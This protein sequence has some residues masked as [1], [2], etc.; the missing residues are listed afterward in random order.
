MA[1]T[2]EKM[3]HRTVNNM[4]HHGAFASSPTPSPQKTKVKPRAAESNKRETKPRAAAKNVHRTPDNM[5]FSLPPLFLHQENQSEA[6]VQR[7][8]KQ[9]RQSPA[10]LE[11]V[12]TE[13]RTTWSFRILSRCA[14]LFLIFFFKFRCA[15]LHFS[16]LGGARD[17]RKR[18][19]H[20]VW[21]SVCIFCRCARLCLLFVLTLPHGASL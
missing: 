18:K 11:K 4:E 12:H 17:G 16:F 10:Q 5:E 8:Q 2:A 15:G 9:R 13:R 3:V 6:P 7:S 19:L 21:R 20:V 1:R 14:G